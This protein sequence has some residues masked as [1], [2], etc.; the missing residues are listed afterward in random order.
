MRN[1]IETL[2]SSATA[3]A[4]LNRDR[5]CERPTVVPARRQAEAVLMRECTDAEVEA[6]ERAYLAAWNAS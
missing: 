6:W 4:R 5:G 1:P 2:V 3:R